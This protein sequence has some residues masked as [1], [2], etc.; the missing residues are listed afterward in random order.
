MFVLYPGDCC[1]LHEC[2]TKLQCDGPE[3]AAGSVVRLL[4]QSWISLLFLPSSSSLPLP[5]GCR[6]D[7]LSETKALTHGDKPAS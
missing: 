4:L 2:V 5:P 6:I 1:R 3:K 7:N